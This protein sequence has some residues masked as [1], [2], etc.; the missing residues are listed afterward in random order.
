MLGNPTEYARMAAAEDDHWWYR[1]L[2]VLV[3]RTVSRHPAGRQA[4]VVDAGCGTGGLLRFL[5][6]EGCRALEGFDVSSEAV[7]RARDRGLAVR[8]AD[9]RDPGL[10]PGSVDV[11]ASLDTLYFLGDEAQETVVRGW[12]EAVAPGGLLVLNLPALGCFRGLHDVAVGIERRFTLAD[13]GRLLLP[14]GFTPLE[15]RFWPFLVSPAI[16]AV[17][18][19]Q[20]LR[21]VLGA[22]MPRSDLDLPPRWLNTALTQVTRWEIEHIPPPPWGS[23]LFVVARRP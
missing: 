11:L 17:R 7:A 8:C 6:R 22:S 15:V 5:A 16:Y 12:F 21:R 3:A 4:R 10:A 18:L 1:T 9:L 13:V 23:S 14:A 19:R 20:R 2:H